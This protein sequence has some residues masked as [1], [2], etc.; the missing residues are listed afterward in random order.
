MNEGRA[1][2]EPKVVEILDPLLE[3]RCH[4]DPLLAVFTLSNVFVPEF[5][6]RVLI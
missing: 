2:V 6:L 3:L 5:G 4:L 1:L